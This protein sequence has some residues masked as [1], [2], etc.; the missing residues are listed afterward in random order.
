MASGGKATPRQAGALLAEL[1]R[2]LG[3]FEDV[4]PVSELQKVADRL[5]EVATA[6][7]RNSKPWTWRYLRSVL[8]GT[9]EPSQRLVNAILK[10]GALIDGAPVEAVKGE[11]VQVLALGKV[12]PGSVI[13]AS[14]KACGNP[15]CKVTFVP[16]VPWQRF[17]SQACAAAWRKQRGK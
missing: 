5:S 1:I 6:G 11:R 17:H 12:A 8:S 9:V 7:G 4:I 2:S 3:H 13:L 10:L 16:V 15:G 14:S